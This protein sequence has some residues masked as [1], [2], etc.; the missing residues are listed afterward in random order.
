YCSQSQWPCRAGEELSVSACP[1]SELSSRIT[2]TGDPHERQAPWLLRAQRIGDEDLDDSEARRQENYPYGPV[3]PS[4]LLQRRQ[5]GRPETPMRKEVPDR[6]PPQ[7]F[8]PPDEESA[9]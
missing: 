6:I 9:R 5:Q 8:A 1:P 3:A 2:Q 4:A 7:T